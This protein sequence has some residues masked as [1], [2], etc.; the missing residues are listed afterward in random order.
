MPVGRVGD[1]ATRKLLWWNLGLT[2]FVRAT[3]DATTTPNRGNWPGEEVDEA[4]AVVARS[5]ELVGL[6]PGEL[7]Q[8]DAGPSL[9]VDDRLDDHVLVAAV[10]RGRRRRRADSAAEVE[11]VAA[12][13]PELAFRSHRRYPSS[14]SSFL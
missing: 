12:S 5:T 11:R 4:G 7:A 6:A 1:D 10:S 13:Q 8:V 3:N 2:N 9:V 14:S